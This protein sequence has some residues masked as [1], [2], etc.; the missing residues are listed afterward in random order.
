MSI[1]FSY[2]RRANIFKQARNISVDK[3]VDRKAIICDFKGTK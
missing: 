3:S 2:C 1:D